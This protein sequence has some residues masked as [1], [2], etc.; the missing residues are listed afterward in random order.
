MH[1]CWARVWIEEE[2]VR[3]S[4]SNISTT[5]PSLDELPVLK[6]FPTDSTKSSPSPSASPA[7]TTDIHSQRVRQIMRT[8]PQSVVILT[9][10]ASSTP[11][12]VDW[13]KPGLN[14]APDPS[15]YRGMTLSSFTSLSMSRQPLATFNIG[16]PSRTLSALTENQHCLIHVLKSNPR[17]ADLAKAFTRGNIV[18]STIGDSSL[19]AEIDKENAGGHDEK[20]ITAFDLAAQTDPKV[21]VEAHTIRRPRRQDVHLPIIKS[22]AVRAVFECRVLAQSEREG[23]GLIRI[24]DHVLVIARIT[25]V[26]EV[27]DYRPGLLQLRQGRFSSGTALCYADG[28]YA[29]ANACRVSTGTNGVTGK[30]E[31]MVGDLSGPVGATGQT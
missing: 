8:L 26:A 18:H 3:C 30:D 12:V 2:Y 20:S 21:K 24:G 22:P 25:G 1:R 19:G 16:F 28:E 13:T 4:Q 27:G 29:A 11:G 7:A 14:E 31:K 15:L 23:G 6:Y 17:G 9:T 5:F 10:T